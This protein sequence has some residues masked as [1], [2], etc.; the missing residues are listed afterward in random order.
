MATKT[1]CTDVVDVTLAPSFD[2][3]KN[4]VGVPEAPARLDTQTPVLQE[5]LTAGPAGV[6]K[7]AG[8][9]HGIQGAVRTDTL[10]SQE[11][12]LSEIGRLRAQLPLMHTVR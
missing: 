6:T 9:S 7:L 5:F 11:D 4:V 8:G 10:I 2:D 1:E 12:L 3:R